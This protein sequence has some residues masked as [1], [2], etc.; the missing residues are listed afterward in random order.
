[1]PSPSR[2]REVGRLAHEKVSIAV[3]ERAAHAVNFSHPE[4]LSQLIELWLDGALSAERDRLPRGV[5]M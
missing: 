5:R 4:E 3:I 1:M 2:V